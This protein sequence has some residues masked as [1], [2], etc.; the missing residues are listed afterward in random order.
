MSVPLI[1]AA[2]EEELRRRAKAERKNVNEHVVA[3]DGSEQSERYHARRKERGRS[4][5][6]CVLR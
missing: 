5:V 3:V 1:V 2:D 6:D 4:N